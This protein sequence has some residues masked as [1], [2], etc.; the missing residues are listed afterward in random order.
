MQASES[1]AVAETGKGASLHPAVVF[2]VSPTGLA[3][4]RSLAPRG[5]PV[6]GVDENRREIGHYSRWFRRDPRMA[7]LSPG[8]ELLEAL[9]RFGAE[10]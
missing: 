4:A 5:V 2:T 3:V 10:Q 9:M 7:Y 1:V 8:P 6:W